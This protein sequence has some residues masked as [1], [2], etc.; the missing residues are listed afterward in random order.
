MQQVQRQG[1]RFVQHDHRLRHVVQLAAA[2][3]AGGEKAFEE[4]HRR[5]YDHRCVPVLRRPAQLADGVASGAAIGF[6]GGRGRAQRRLPVEAR[7]MFEHARIV[8]ERVVEDGGG[9]LNDGGVRD[10]VDYAAQPVPA[11]MFQ[12]R[13]AM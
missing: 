13:T 7:I 8:A 4:L 6:G 12:P 3:G 5:R 1:L 2:A 11:R 10:D 9:L